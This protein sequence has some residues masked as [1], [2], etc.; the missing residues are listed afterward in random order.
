MAN[1]LNRKQRTQKRHYRSR[2]RLEGTTERPR[3]AVFRSTKHIYVQLI[4]DSTGSTITSA[5]SVDKALKGDLSHGGDL[6]AAGKVGTLIAERAQ[7]AGV[8]NVV[9]DRGGNI[10]HGRVAAL[11]ESAREAG[12]EF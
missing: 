4:D 5:S 6:T 1:Q 2:R 3:L 7:K 9:F 8:K 11:A 12:L 10:Y